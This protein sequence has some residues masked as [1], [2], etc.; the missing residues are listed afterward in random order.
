MGDAPA[1]TKGVYLHAI[2]KQSTATTTDYK[3]EYNGTSLQWNLSTME[4][5]GNS[6]TVLHTEASSI[7]RLIH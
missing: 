4:T 5:T 1:S 2:I 7:Q 6:E 3:N